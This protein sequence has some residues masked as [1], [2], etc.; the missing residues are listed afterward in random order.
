MCGEAEADR[1]FHLFDMLRWTC[2]SED[3]NHLG[4]RIPGTQCRP[5]SQI[6]LGRG[7]PV[8]L[9]KTVWGPLD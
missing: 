8:I 3:K 9:T 1:G 7:L 5:A 4:N 2:V 6:S